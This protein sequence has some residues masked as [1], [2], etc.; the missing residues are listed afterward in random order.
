MS[1]KHILLSAG[2]AAMF[3]FQSCGGSAH[4]PST[5]GGSVMSTVEALKSNDVSGIL[6]SV[7]TAEQKKKLSDE[8][9][10]NRKAE[11]PDQQN[12]M[13]AA[14]FEQF[15]SGAMN[16]M[17]MAQ[18]TPALQSI[19]KSKLINMVQSINLNSSA[20]PDMTPEQKKQAEAA[21]A[22]FTKWIETA[23][24]TNPENVR[25]VL[26][27]AQKGANNLG[28]SSPK[29]LAALNFDQALEKADVVVG[30]LKDALKV[31]GIS[32]DDTL[33]SIKVTKVEETG[34][35]ATV[36]V[37][38]EAFGTKHTGTTTFVKIGNR[39]Y[40]EDARKAMLENMG[41]GF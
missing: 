34:D 4:D 26:A 35:K 39:W 41:P 30:V 32:L 14:Q 8:W 2:T 33:N 20:T 27:I 1:F 6:D 3:C 23:D 31:Y 10:K 11:I 19:D 37:E 7:L 22:S 40:G 36:T 38:Y 5:P 28:V 13:M 16:D 29:E 15:K 25:K 17:I 21:L 12:E 18:V 9:D 24:I